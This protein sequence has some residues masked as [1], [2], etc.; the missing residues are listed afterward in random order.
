MTPKQVKQWA[1]TKLAEIEPR[2]GS[3]PAPENAALVAEAKALMYSLGLHDFA[4][5]LP[6]DA[7]RKS[8]L[9]AAN[10]LRRVI[11][12]LEAPADTQRDTLTPSEVAKQLK[13]SPDAVLAWIKSG[14]LKASNLA[15]G[16]KPR[17]TV[18]KSDLA[19]F[20]KSKQAPAPA[21]PKPRARRAPQASGNYQRY[22]R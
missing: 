1:T 7:E 14:E 3:A 16:R 13:K 19:A 15:T 6:D 17:W 2:I 10:Q 4:L 5:S 21:P 12:A 20:L 18:T 9:T 11:A 22:S 8:A